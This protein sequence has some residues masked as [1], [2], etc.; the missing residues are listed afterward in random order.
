MVNY[1][2]L[3]L[4][5]VEAGIAAVVSYFI[6]TGLGITNVTWIIMIMT[7]FTVLISSVLPW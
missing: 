6:V 5:S 2:K 7:V 1:L 4:K 3:I